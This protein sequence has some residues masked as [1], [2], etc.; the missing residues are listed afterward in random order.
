MIVPAT[1]GGI[2]QANLQG[3][4]RGQNKGC[5]AENERRYASA[6]LKSLRRRRA[7]SDALTK[8]SRPL[9]V[10]SECLLFRKS[11]IQRGCILAA[12]S[13]SAETKGRAPT[14]LGQTW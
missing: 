11:G 14:F 5:G 4:A 9:R 6:H 2:L 8:S 12:R 7:S 10:T 13:Y 1:A 3:R